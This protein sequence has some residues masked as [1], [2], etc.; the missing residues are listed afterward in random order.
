MTLRWLLENDVGYAVG[1]VSS[2]EREADSG[3]RHHE[4]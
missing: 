1:L 2:V 3:S 4:E